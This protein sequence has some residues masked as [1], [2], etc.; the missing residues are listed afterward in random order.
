MFERLK[1]HRLLTQIVLSVLGGMAG[2]GYYYYIGCA[3]GTCPITGSPY[4]S[5]LYGMALGLLLAPGQ[6]KKKSS[7]DHEPDRS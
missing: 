3:S 5:T 2:F 7:D 1:S 6:I 4:V